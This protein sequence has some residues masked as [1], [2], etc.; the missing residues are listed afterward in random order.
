M[1]HLQDPESDDTGDDKQRHYAEQQNLLGIV[2]LG[3]FVDLLG[4]IPYLLLH[5]IAKARQQRQIGDTCTDH[6]DDKCDFT[7]QYQ[8]TLDRLLMTDHAGSHDNR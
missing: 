3:V 4:F 2:A 8:D 1:F 6:V 5:G 7:K